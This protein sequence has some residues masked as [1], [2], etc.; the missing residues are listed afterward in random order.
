VILATAHCLVLLLTP[1]LPIIAVLL[2]WNSNTVAHYFLHSP[3]FRARSL[4]LL[5]AL[6]LSILL[7]FPQS[8]WR[9]R[10]L[11]HHAGIRPRLRPS[12]QVIAEVLLIA[13]LWALLLVFAPGFFLTVYAP[14]YLTGLLLCAL[15]GHYEHPNAKTVSHYG[16]L[17]NCLFLN[18]G[19]H[20]EHHAHP[21]SSWTEL[22]SKALPEAIGSR[23]PAILRWLDTFSLD[24]LERLVVRAPSLQKFVLRRHD[25]ALTALLS[26]S[27]VARAAIVGGGLFPRSALLLRRLMPQ[28][29]L[30]VIDACAKNLEVARAFLPADVKVVQDRYDP[31]RHRGFDMVVIPLAYVGDRAALYRRPPAPILLVHDWLWRQRGSSRVVSWFLLKRLN[32]VRQ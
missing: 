18:D 19:Y 9:E 7:G 30:V 16:R 12:H 22:R 11:A 26:G 27:V 1:T 8:V 25:H 14:G 29:E 17:Y 24:G 15:H 20:V 2:W 5:F 23:W 31:E 21:E 10:H 3:F 4:N 28:T 32:L 6:Y 13:A